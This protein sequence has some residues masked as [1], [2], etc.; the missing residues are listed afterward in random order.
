[1]RVALV[2]LSIVLAGC[3]AGGP[4]L[5]PDVH[6][7]SYQVDLEVKDAHVQRGNCLG[8]IMA[9]GDECHVLEVEVTC[10]RLLGGSRHPANHGIMIAGTWTA[11]P[12]SIHGW[13]D[14]G[15]QILAE[16]E[17]ALVR[18]EFTVP[19]GT[20]PFQALRLDSGQ[21][22]G[23]AKVPAYPPGPL[24]EQVA[25][26]AVKSVEVLAGRCL[27]GRNSRECHRATIEVDNRNNTHELDVDRMAWSATDRSGGAYGMG[28]VHPQGPPRVA[29]GA[30][31]QMTVDFELVSGARL[32]QVRVV[33]RSQSLHLSATAPAY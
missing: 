11:H 6:M 14:G 25:S 9:F 21:A 20:A 12:G 18:V 23:D 2:L 10:C 13:T 19:K 24:D 8:G 28:D 22:T 15:A 27:D 5:W 17:M 26:L 33:D 29:A 31:L 7:P 3:T 4:G 32:D 30:R 16:G 1:M